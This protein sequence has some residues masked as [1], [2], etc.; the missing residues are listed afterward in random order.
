MFLIILIYFHGIYKT[1]LGML[2]A[3]APASVA[4]PTPTTLPLPTINPSPSI[5][6]STKPSVVP[7]KAT[8]KPKPSPAQSP[9]PQPQSQ[10]SW[11]DRPTAEAAVKT[12]AMKEWG[13]D[14]RMV[15]YEFNLQMEAYSWLIQ[16]TQYPPYTPAHDPNLRELFIDGHQ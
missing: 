15:E 12:K 10:P 14:Y 16:Q 7:A 13:D 5:Q 2:S 8:S 4:T 11:P 9:T 6:A 3:L 1:K